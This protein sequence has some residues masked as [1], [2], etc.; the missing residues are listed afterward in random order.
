MWS[1]SRLHCDY[2][3]RYVSAVA[4]DMCAEAVP[5]AEAVLEADVVAEADVVVA[6]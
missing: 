5:E 4:F 6:A 1:Y 3:Y 2:G